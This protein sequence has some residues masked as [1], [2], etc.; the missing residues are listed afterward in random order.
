[1]A[2]RIDPELREHVEVALCRVK[3]RPG[4]GHVEMMA[5]YA[6]A[7]ILAVRTHDSAV[8]RADEKLSE[9]RNKPIPG[10]WI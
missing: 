8:E 1:M 5:A 6:E 10:G 4:A 3:V 2:E 9:A 7:A